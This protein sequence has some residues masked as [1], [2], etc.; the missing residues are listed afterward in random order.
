VLFL[1]F[2]KAFDTV[3]HQRLLAKLQY[4]GITGRTHHWISQWLTNRMQRVVISGT[5]SDYINVISGVPQGTM[6]GPLM[7]L[8]YINDISKNIIS[9]IR[10][11]ADDCVVYQLISNYDDT[12]VLQND[13]DVISNWAHV[14][15]MKFNVN[16]CVLLRVTRNH[17]PFAS[18]YSLNGQIIQLSY[19]YK[20]LR[21]LLTSTLSWNTHITNIT[22][23]A[24]RMLNFLKRN[25]GK[26]TNQVKSQAYMLLVC[27]ILEYA[28]QV[29]D[30]Y[31]KSSTRKIEMIQRRTA[32]WVFK[33]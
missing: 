26:C 32:R 18:K 13:L 2:A 17:S 19:M 24:T 1:D 28:T 29:W 25:L 23:Q 3:P 22:N 9:S 31:Q 4:Y 20:Y 8:L 7:F 30:P 27:P 10:L 6:L 16:K 11:F 33:L 14:W 21:V 12:T 5:E 15:Q